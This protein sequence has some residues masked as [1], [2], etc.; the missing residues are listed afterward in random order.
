MRNSKT[1]P[2]TST[3]C[4]PAEVA[5]YSKYPQMSATVILTVVLFPVDSLPSHCNSGLTVTVNNNKT[6]DKNENEKLH[7]GQ[8]SLGLA[9]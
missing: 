1:P 4:R 8:N 9:R 6:K 7:L 5:R 2:P 3:L